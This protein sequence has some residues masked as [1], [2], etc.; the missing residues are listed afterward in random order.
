MNRTDRN[1]L[2]IAAVGLGVAFWAQRSQARKERRR[3]AHLVGEPCD[4][5][6]APP[7]G[8]VCVPKGDGFVFQRS[9]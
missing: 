9:A 7:E 6:G 3:N 2:L 1:L 8:F 4:P 5:L